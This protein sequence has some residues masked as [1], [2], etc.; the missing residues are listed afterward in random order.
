MG[1]FEPWA[2][3]PLDEYG[4]GVGVEVNA[5]RSSGEIDAGWTIVEFEPGSW[6]KLEKRVG[7]D[8]LTKKRVLLGTMLQANPSFAPSPDKP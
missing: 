7:N 1:E 8:V 5:L 4:F 3:E 2:E 6:Y